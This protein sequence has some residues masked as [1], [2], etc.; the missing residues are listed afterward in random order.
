ME[1]WIALGYQVHRVIEG[2]IL[3]R[4]GGRIRLFAFDE[5]SVKKSGG[6]GCLE[7]VDLCKGKAKLI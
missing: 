1:W 2:W 6:E 5:S 4:L 3:M 7:D